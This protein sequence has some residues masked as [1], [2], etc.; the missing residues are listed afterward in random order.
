MNPV[1]TIEQIA[2]REP[3]IDNAIIERFR[4]RRASLVKVLVDAYL[5]EGPRYFQ[6]LR[7]SVAAGDFAAARSA[8]HG[9]KSCSYNLGAVRLAKICQETEST[10]LANNIERLTNALGHVGP[11][12]FATE[13]ALKSIR[14]SIAGAG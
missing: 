14:L 6:D 13:E 5:E 12:L 8:A 9:L 1:E 11:A 10:A 2:Q 3:V 7:K 4:Q